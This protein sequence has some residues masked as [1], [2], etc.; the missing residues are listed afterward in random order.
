MS[1]VRTIF[2]V[3]LALLFKQ[4]AQTR[5]YNPHN[6]VSIAAHHHS[7]DTRYLRHD[8]GRRDQSH[9]C[10]VRHDVG[11]AR[12]EEECELEA[13]VRAQVRH[14]QLIPEHERWQLRS[15]D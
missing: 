12:M 9:G 6:K 11:P 2:N 15:V 1:F 8:S 3:Y 5:V 7:L 14:P 10:A 4:R 13:Q